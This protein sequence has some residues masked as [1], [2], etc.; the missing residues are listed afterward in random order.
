[1]LRCHGEKSNVD[2]KGRVV[3]LWLAIHIG[4]SRREFERRQAS[5]FTLH[6][7]G[8]LTLRLF[9]SVLVCRCGYA[10]LHDVKDKTQ[11]D[12]MESFFLSETSK[13]LYLVSITG[14]LNSP[15]I[16]LVN[17]LSIFRLLVRIP[18]HLHG[19]TYS[20]AGN[21]LSQL[22]SESMSLSVSQ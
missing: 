2:E 15:A 21:S 20:L 5:Y 7:Y 6:V 4:L 22:I 13:Y 18:V 11:E 10:T 3:P 17:R 14:K 9:V 8:L 1:M 19:V 12:R 16:E